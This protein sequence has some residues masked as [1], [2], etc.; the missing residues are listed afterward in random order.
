M[1]REKIFL[2][3]F[4]LSISLY[5][6]NLNYSLPN[7]YNIIIFWFS[8]LIIFSTL[9]LQ[10]F[11]S[12]SDPKIIL[13]EIFIIYLLLHLVYQVGYF[14]LRGSDSYFE[15]NFLKK[16]LSQ[17][18]FLLEGWIE[19]WPII[20]I[21]SAILCTIT[22]LDALTVA[23]F[24]P[25]V[26]S[27]LIVFPLYLLVF[28][29]YKEKNVA[30]LATLVYG[31][32]PQFVY[33]ESLFVKEAYGLLIIIS[34]FY[35]IYT[36]NIKKDSRFAFLSVILIPVLVLSHQFTSFMF[37]ILM[38]IYL[39]LLFVFSNFSKINIANIERIDN[40]NINNVYILLFVVLISYW[41]YCEVFIFKIF[42][43]IFYNIIGVEEYTSYANQISLGSPIITLKGKIIY[44]GFYF[45][46]VLFAGLLI[47]RIILVK[48]RL[49]IEDLLFTVFFILCGIYGFLALYVLGSLIY[50]L[51]FLGHA[52]LF[53]I[54][55]LIGYVCTLRN[56]N[57]KKCLL[58]TLFVFI[59]FNIYNID[60]SY[61]SGNPSVLGAT[62]NYED[63]MIARTIVFPSYYYLNDSNAVYY[64]DAGVSGAIYDI[65]EVDM[66][67]KLRSVYNMKDFDNS[68]NIAI[69][70]EKSLLHNIEIIKQKSDSDYS[71]IIKII[72]YKDMINVNKI[73]EVSNGYY[74][75]KG[76]R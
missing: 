67:T 52:W 64:A 20:H 73:C 50:P 22:K 58:F 61:I 4:F 14:G 48:N 49:K 10:I 57:Y 46:H 62:S 47:Q 17:G 11:R 74:I 75:L 27:S 44:Y 38:T 24:I 13:L 30:M 6:S 70:N 31:T 71:K 60:P 9:M 2:S 76:G 15:Y 65:Q 33:F 29:L 69:I 26:I 41:T 43:N 53:G 42:H 36:A 55:P 7:D 23:K 28:S 5:I 56:A 21:F 72:S 45:F 68:S 66:S 63:Y 19:G 18:H 32:I 39:T 8:I 25:S 12:K 16:I 51:R 54:I 37:L 35:L 1:N 59:L 40:Y 3:L 34:L